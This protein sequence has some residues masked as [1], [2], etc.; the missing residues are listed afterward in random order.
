MKRNQTIINLE[1]EF[2]TSYLF[3][4]NKKIYGDVIKADIKL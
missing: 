1:V 3:Y 2:D 4:V